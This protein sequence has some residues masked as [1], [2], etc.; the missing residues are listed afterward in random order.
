L[1]GIGN[2][3]I[4]LLRLMVWLEHNLFFFIVNILVSLPPPFLCRLIR[5]SPRSFLS[6]HGSNVASTSGT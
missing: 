3:V 5:C 1:S 4:V 6:F 2:I